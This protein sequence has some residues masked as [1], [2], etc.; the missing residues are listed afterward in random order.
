MSCQYNHQTCIYKAHTSTEVKI[1][2]SHNFSSMIVTLQ[3]TLILGIVL[4]DDSFV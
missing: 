4:H 3:C 2:I 1:L